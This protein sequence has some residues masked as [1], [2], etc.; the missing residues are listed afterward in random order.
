[1]AIALAGWVRISG[2]LP[3]WLVVSVGVLTG[4]VV[5]GGMGLL[6]RVHELRVGLQLG[7]RRLRA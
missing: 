4:L 3:T 7:L 1:M 5:Y 2:E 6:L